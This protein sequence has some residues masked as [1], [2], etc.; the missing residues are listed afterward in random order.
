MKVAVY[1][2]VSTLDQDPLTQE[3]ICLEYCRRNDHTVYKVYTDNGVSGMKASRP[4]FNQLL[5]DM[6]Q[7]KFN[8]IIT[9][10]LDR[11]GRSL[12]HILAI[13]EEISSRGI[14]FIA[15]TQS[16]DTSSAA[17]KCQLQILGAFAE[18]ERNIISE[19]T[20]EALQFVK[21]VGKRGPDK[22]TRKKRGGTRPALIIMAK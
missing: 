17:G 11:I 22:K 20:R 6:R 16:I 4:A 3:R 8:C 18:F 7:N 19:R 13:F 2:R 10:K 15:T 12:Q 9:T 1:C 5:Q 14:H 21:N